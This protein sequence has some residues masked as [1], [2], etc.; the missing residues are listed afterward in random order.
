MSYSNNFTMNI[1][2]L[3]KSIKAFT[4]KGKAAIA[5]EMEQ[6]AKELEGYMKAKAPWQDRTGLARRSL[7]AEVKQSTMKVQITLYN[8]VPYGIYLEQF[9]G[10][11]FAI[12]DPTIKAKSPDV[13]RSLQ[14]VFNKV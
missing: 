8:P 1:P 13:M 11:R 10:K 7:K 9:M 4:K 3:T 5:N 2:K 12:I 6:Q 14:G